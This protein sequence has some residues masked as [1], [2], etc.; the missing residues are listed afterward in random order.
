MGHTLW[1]LMA[2]IATYR[3]VLPFSEKSPP[4]IP[5]SSK[6]INKKKATKRCGTG[7]KK[8]NLCLRSM[9]KMADRPEI[10]AQDRQK[11]TAKRP[12]IDR[13]KFPP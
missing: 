2:E 8:Q 1:P 7:D 5:L 11:L 12:K 10:P 13:Q 9:P 6:K 3:T 4:P